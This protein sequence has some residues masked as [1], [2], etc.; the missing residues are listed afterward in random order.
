MSGGG[1]Q[2]AQLTHGDVDR[3]AA[4]SFGRRAVIVATK[5]A[6]RPGT[7]ASGLMKGCAGAVRY[8]SV[9]LT[10]SVKC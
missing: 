7:R 3:E 5:H 6:L 8:A 4:R 10:G 2:L 1:W 9:I